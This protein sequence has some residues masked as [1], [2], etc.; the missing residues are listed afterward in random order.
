MRLVAF[1]ISFLFV[2]VA[3]SA[4][5]AHAA[6]IKKVNFNQDEEGVFA[7]LVFDKAV[8]ARSL[9]WGTERNFGQVV[10]KNA[11]MDSSKIFRASGSDVE[12][13]MVYP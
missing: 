3:M 9:H 11:V 2:T 5:F 10:I 13:V 7:E 4:S 6:K 12:K 1:L 8:S